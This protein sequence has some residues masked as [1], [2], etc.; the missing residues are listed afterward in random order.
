MDSGLAIT[1]VGAIGSALIT[2]GTGVGVVWKLGGAWGSMT[3]HVKNM[4]ARV[5]DI[6]ILSETTATKVSAID[7][8]VHTLER[9]IG[10][11]SPKLKAGGM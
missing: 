3:E 5:D 11:E 1:L 8:R 6:C 7:I 9:V 2:I 10:T 4:G